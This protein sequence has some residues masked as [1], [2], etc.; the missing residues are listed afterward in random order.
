MQTVKIVGLGLKINPLVNHGEELSYKNHDDMFNVQRP[1]VQN[2]S[3]IS[4]E[5][6]NLLNMISELAI[7]ATE[8][9]MSS[10]RNCGYDLTDDD[11]ALCK[12]FASNDSVENSLESLCDYGNKYGSDTASFFR[13]LGNFKNS[14]NPLDMLRKLSTNLVYH[15]SNIYGFMGG[16]YPIQGASLGGMLA[17]SAA[18]SDLN[19][20]KKYALV[21]ATGDMLSVDSIASFQ[22]MNMI[23]TASNGGITPSFASVSLMMSTNIDAD[24]HYLAEILTCKT[25]YFVGT[26]VLKHWQK[27]Y[28]RLFRECEDICRDQPV[29]LVQYDNGTKH[30]STVE[31]TAIHEFFPHAIV[32]TYKRQTGYTGTANSLLDLCLSLKDSSIPPGA[33]IVLNGTGFN[34]GIGCVVY[35]KGFF[36]A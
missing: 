32:K 30:L 34:T 33:L 24:K 29:Y 23:R 35:R 11:R 28:Q 15:L 7:D 16:G 9:C 12:I 6:R 18:I 3:L 21:S 4:R 13:N 14:A 1:R 20:Q 31:N 5:N 17:V 10:V 2:K 8:Q 27:L 26:P 22:K 36:N 19:Y 25:H